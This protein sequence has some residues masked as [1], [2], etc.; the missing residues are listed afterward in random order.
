MRFDCRIPRRLDEALGF[1]RERLEVLQRE[2]RKR[3]NN[4]RSGIIG[5]LQS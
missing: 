1:A 5:H 3:R 2:L 4:A